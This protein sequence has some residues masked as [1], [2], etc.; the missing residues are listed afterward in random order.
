MR[1]L[2]S[3]AKTA[4]GEET[5]YYTTDPPP[6]VAKGSLPGDEI[7]TYGQLT[8]H[9]LTAWCWLH[10]E[11]R[12]MSAAADPQQSWRPDGRYTDCGQRLAWRRR[13]SP[14]LQKQVIWFWAAS[15][16]LAERLPAAA[17]GMLGWRAQQQAMLS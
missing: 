14:A 8:L 11:C 15:S 6:N 9:L 10:T 2:L 13:H 12:Q 1:H 7:F 16:R 17:V 5:I 3:M 4:L